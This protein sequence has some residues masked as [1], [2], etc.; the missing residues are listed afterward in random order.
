M[1]GI[2]YKALAGV[3]ITLLEQL[4]ILEEVRDAAQAYLDERS[5]AWL[6]SSTADEFNERLGYIED[7]CS[8]LED[9][10]STIANIQE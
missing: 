3:R 1:K 10:L 4:E 8:E 6:E 5:D 9:L 7:S 2:N